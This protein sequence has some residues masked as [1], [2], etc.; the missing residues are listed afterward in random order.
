MGNARSV[1]GGRFAGD[2]DDDQFKPEVP[3]ST[4]FSL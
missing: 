4:G 1:P 2:V 3:T